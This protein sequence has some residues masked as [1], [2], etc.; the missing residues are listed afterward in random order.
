MDRTDCKVMTSEVLEY[1]DYNMTL[2]PCSKNHIPQNTPMGC[3]TNAHMSIS[4]SAIWLTDL[5]IFFY[6]VHSQTV[7]IAKGTLY[8][9]SA[10]MP[11]ENELL[12][13]MLHSQHVL[14]M[15][16]YCSAVPSLKALC[17]RRIDARD[18][19]YAL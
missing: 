15:S 6:L 11:E 19:E 8:C 5:F 4:I 3:F 1:C 17:T 10:L 18:L 13:R 7:N 14:P 9:T 16:P 12:M 2:S